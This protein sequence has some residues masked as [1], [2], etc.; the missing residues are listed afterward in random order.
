MSDTQIASL[1]VQG[2]AACVTLTILGHDHK[3][4]ALLRHA[5]GT[6][7]WVDRFQVKLYPDPQRGIGLSAEQGYDTLAKALEGFEKLYVAV[8]R[9]AAE[10]AA[11][12]V[13]TELS[14]QYRRYLP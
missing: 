13:L 4:A 9:R 10:R 5:P 14:E 12:A 2:T 11:E 8:S 1:V 6:G 3:V 7:R